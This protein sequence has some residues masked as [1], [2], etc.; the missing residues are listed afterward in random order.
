[1]PRT[2]KMPTENRPAEPAG[3]IDQAD[4]AA[5]ALPIGAHPA[6]KTKARAG[7]GR[8]QEIVPDPVSESLVA[9]EQLQPTALG[10]PTRPAR[11]VAK[12]RATVARQEQAAPA[13]KPTTDLPPPA[14]EVS[15]RKTRTRRTRAASPM[16]DAPPAEA[17]RTS[18][19]EV[20]PLQAPAEKRRQTKQA[21]L[22]EMLQ[23]PEG[24]TIAELSAATGWQH[25]SVR[26]AISGAVKKQLD[27]EVTSEQVK[28]RGRVY[29]IA[30]RAAGKRR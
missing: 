19:K 20:R 13:A 29:R 12:A 7:A 28:E 5:T 3:V 8:Q 17:T 30:A 11:K 16:A 14:P 10:P 2:R 25:H 22:I 18:K 1:M 24:A 9:T 21:L 27:L 26:G 6:G 23:R 15:T 4:P